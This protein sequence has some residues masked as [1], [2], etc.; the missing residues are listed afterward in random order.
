LLI[1]KILK[2][3]IRKVFLPVTV[4]LSAGFQTGALAGSGDSSGVHTPVRQSSTLRTDL[5]KSVGLLKPSKLKIFQASPEDQEDL[6]PS[7]PSIPI[8]FSGYVRGFFQY[9]DMNKYYQDM[10]G[11]P[12]NITVNGV[13]NVGS[14]LQNGYP[15]PFLMLQADANPT[16][17]TSVTVQ[18]YL[19]NQMTGQRS[20]SGRQALLYRLFNFKGNIYSNFGTFSLTA[21]GGVNWA[22]MSPF[23]LGNNIQF[24]RQ[25]LF[26]RLPWQYYGSSAARYSSNYTDEN[27]AVD[28]RWSR[29]GTQGFM[30]EGSGLPAG[31]GFMA[32]YGKTD[33]SGGFRSYVQTSNS[34]I[35]NFLAGRLY[36]NYFGHEIGINYFSQFGYTNAYQL[37][38]EQQRILTMD[39]KLKPRNL[40]IYLEVGAGSYR[41]PDYKEKWT[42]TANLQVQVD[43]KVIG[44]PFS[45]QLYEV[46]SSVVNI[47]SDVMNSSIPYVQPS[48][49]IQGT[50]N[51]LFGSSDITTFPGIMTEVGQLT[52]NRKGLNI[53]GN[54]SIGNLKIAFG[55]S[56]NQEIENKY[57]SDPRYNVVQFNHRLN[58]FTRSRFAYYT[59]GNGPYASITNIYRRTFE[60]VQITDVNPNYLKSFNAVDLT[61]KYKINLFKKELIL[62]NYT[63]YSTAQD[64]LSAVPLTDNSAFVRYFY[65]EFNA[66][67]PLH[68]KV[69][70]VGQFG[71]ETM[72]GGDRTSMVDNQGNLITNTDGSFA[73]KPVGGKARDQLGTGIG[74]GV[75]YDFSERAGLFF[76]HRFFHHKDKNFTKDEFQG[77]ESS[78][79]LKIFF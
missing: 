44:M 55:Y 41:S 17:R 28:T 1:E 8:R 30:L 18:Y 10:Y 34:P 68:K 65:E 52:N 27:V 26:E 20:D 62:V 72:K 23:T 71:V 54:T 58:A 15:E 60:T 49:P 36:N 53:K 21:G 4:L 31:F 67:Y 2:T 33:N 11:G 63:T 43:K 61:L 14:N 79:E 3:L 24:Y 76:R 64:H 78:V 13:N 32:L 22:R 56:V 51:S 73:A 48:Y 29:A 37:K 25:D 50:T 59:S 35:K 57:G 69:T 45:V 40:D 5:L 75:D 19:D 16:A 42:P 12:N 74:L 7:T 47:N 46:G 66:F 6:K 70:L 9:R 38:P 77:Q 39:F